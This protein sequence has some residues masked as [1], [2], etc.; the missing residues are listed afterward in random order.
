MFEFNTSPRMVQTLLAAHQQFSL[1]IVP[2]L[3]GRL[4]GSA[5]YHEYRIVDA[6]HSVLKAR[7]NLCLNSTQAR[8]WCKRS[9]AAHQQFSLKIIPALA[10]R[11]AGSAS[12]TAT[13][14]L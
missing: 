9:L 8:G 2:A 6:G 3:V 10:G 5:L 4:A 13:A 11:M 12:A 7:V 14:T 1:K